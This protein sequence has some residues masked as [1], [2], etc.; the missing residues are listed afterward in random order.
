[1]GSEM[2]IVHISNLFCRFE[3]RVLCKE[4]LVKELLGRPEKFL[5]HHR[6]NFGSVWCRFEE[7]VLLHFD[8]RIIA[9][10]DIPYYFLHTPNGFT[11]C[12]KST[13]RSCVTEP[14]EGCLYCKNPNVSNV[15]HFVT[16]IAK[17]LIP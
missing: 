15:S 12:F 7:L 14:A 11:S 1:M 9:V 5:P 17:Y 6:E 16:Q 3:G 10:K 4:C 2:S 8:H 13:V